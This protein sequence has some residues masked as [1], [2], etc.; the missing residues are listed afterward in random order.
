MVFR[1][2]THRHRFHLLLPLFLLFAFAGDVFAQAAA[3]VFATGSASIVAA[4]GSSRRAERGA[5]LA[6]GETVDTGDGKAQLKFRDG[7]TISLQPGTQFRVEQFR[8]SEQNG[9]AS[10]DDLVVMRFLKGALRAVSGLIGKERQQQYRMDTTVGTIGI[11]GTEYGAT[12]GDGGLSVTTY[13]GLVEVC[14]SAGC[15]QV[16]PGQTLIVPDGNARPRLQSGN[17]LPGLMPGAA[18][19]QLPAP[20]PMTTPVAPQ[21]Q[22]THVPPPNSPGY[23]AGRTY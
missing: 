8:F 18:A 2:N 17:N 19:P 10:E 12:M 5:T 22:E 7:A 9:R 11:R 6:A 4:D 21:Q 20:T 1:K 15:A 14:N 13:S 16:G 23:G 3:I